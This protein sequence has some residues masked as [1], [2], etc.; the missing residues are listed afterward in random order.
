MDSVSIARHIG[1]TASPTEPTVVKS[2]NVTFIETSVCII[3]HEFSS[4][5]TGYECDVLSLTSLF[6]T[7]T[8][9]DD[10]N[11]LNTNGLDYPTQIELLRQER[12]SM[13]QDNLAREEL[14]LETVS[15]TEHDDHLTSNSHLGHADTPSPRHA[16]IT[17]SP[18]TTPNNA[19]Y[20]GARRT[21]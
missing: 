12:K 5:D 15:S 21:L 1:S 8:P 20:P 19:R 4:E 16:S 10:F 14:R 7:D 6:S 18:S 17:P 2:R 3:P 9:A 11:G 13:Q